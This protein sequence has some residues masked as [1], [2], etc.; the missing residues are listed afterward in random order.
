MGHITL[1]LKVALISGF[2]SLIAWVAVYTRLTGGSAWRNPVGLT[3][4][5]K[6]LLIA[7]LF[8]PTGL[9]LFFRF[10]RLTS[11]VAGWIDVALIGLVTPVMAWRTIVWLRIDHAGNSHDRQHGGRPDA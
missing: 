7:V 8:V 10:N 9:S 5:L 11:E 2:V 6:S 3:L 1:C 4:I